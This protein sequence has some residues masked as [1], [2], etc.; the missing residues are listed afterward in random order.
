MICLVALATF[1]FLGIFSAKYRRY[2]KEA[3]NCVFRRITLRKCNTEFDKK[4][5]VMSSAR[6]MNVS[7]PLGSFVFKHFEAIGWAFTILLVVSIIFSAQGIYNLTVYGS[8]DPHS[9]NCVF[10]PGVLTCG[11]EECAVNGCDCEESG[12]EYPGFLACEGY[13]DCQESICG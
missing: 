2:A 13:C 3:F 12:C 10:K 11:S 8:C 1:T 5:K 4:I 6:L 9:T 7:K